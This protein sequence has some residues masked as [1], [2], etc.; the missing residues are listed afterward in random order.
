MAMNPKRVAVIGGGITGLSAALNLLQKG[1][2]VVL[3]E[4]G[5]DTGGLSAS[6]DYGPFRWDK[7]YHCILTSDSALLNLIDQ[8]GLTSEL[9]WQQ[10]EVGFYADKKLYT[11][12]TPWDLLRYPKLSLLDKV[13]LARGVRK[14]AHIAD[15]EPLRNIEIEPWSTSIFGKSVHKSF[16]D[17]LLRCKLGSARHRTS[18]SFLWT[19]LRRLYST[20]NSGPSKREELGYVK[21]GYAKILA[22]LEQ[23][24]RS[25]GGVILTNS[26]ITEVQRVQGHIHVKMQGATTV[27]D[28]ALLTAPVNQAIKM[29]GSRSALGP[30]AAITPEYLGLVCVVL[31]LRRRL[32]KHYVTNLLDELPFTGIIEMTNLISPAEETGGYH[33]VYLPRYICNEDSFQFL[34]DDELWMTMWEALRKV[35]PDLRPRDVVDYFCFRSKT[36]QPIP[37]PATASFNLPA[38]TRIPGVF[39]ASTSQIR[40]STLNNNVMVELSSRA[41]QQVDQYLSNLSHSEIDEYTPVFRR[42]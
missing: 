21:G 35:H 1:H 2:S 11:V 10:T 18:A 5:P 29:L 25:L 15:G 22:A 23:K 30:Q 38:A 17:P 33:L 42:S 34:K 16:W 40:D 20:R 9:R 14:V 36:V 37:T 19:T 28:A 6:F 3:F 8:V 12:T 31:V 13:R 32:S 24:I 41:C 7:F 26:A 4:Q 39:L 27:A